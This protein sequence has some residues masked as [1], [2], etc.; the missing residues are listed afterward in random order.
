MVDHNCLTT[1]H[2]PEDRSLRLPLHCPNPTTGSVAGII[3]RRARKFQAA[4]AAGGDDG[5]ETNSFSCGPV[6]HTLAR[7]ED[8][9]GRG[10]ALYRQ[11]RTG[12]GSNHDRS[13]R[14][15][16]SAIGSRT[17]VSLHSMMRGF[18]LAGVFNRH[19]N[20]HRYV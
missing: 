16:A 7:L 19:P 9:A 18:S 1:A 8:G 5:V 20:G 14:T 17:P 10:F 11:E 4:K 12:K 2:C 13:R 3:E 15:N 6:P